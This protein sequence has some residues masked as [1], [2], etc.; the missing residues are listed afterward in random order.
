MSSNGSLSSIADWL[1]GRTSKVAD[2]SKIKATMVVAMPS[3][4]LCNVPLEGRKNKNVHSIFFD[5]FIPCVTKHYG[6]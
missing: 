2:K 6:V 5:H 1:L 4:S 3:Y